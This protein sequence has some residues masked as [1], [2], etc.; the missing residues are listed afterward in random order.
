MVSVRVLVSSSIETR[1]MDSFLFM[2]CSPPSLQFFLKNIDVF[3]F[4]IDNIGWINVFL[5][6]VLCVCFDLFDNGEK[7]IGS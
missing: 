3:K 7:T 4:F 1:I 6:R 2:L 5:Y